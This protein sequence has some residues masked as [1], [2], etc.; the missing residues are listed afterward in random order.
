MDSYPKITSSIS[1][2]ISY[3]NVDYNIEVLKLR[4]TKHGGKTRFVPQVLNFIL[5]SSRQ[6][7]NN[8]TYNL[9]K[10]VFDFT[11]TLFLWCTIL[12]TLDTYMHI[13]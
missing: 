11:P 2:G 13:L 9:V 7:S 4:F 10:L 12:V 5:L 8:V 1:R 6:F 3:K